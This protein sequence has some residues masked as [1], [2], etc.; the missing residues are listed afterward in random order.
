[1]R[2]MLAS[3]CSRLIPNEEVARPVV[4]RPPTGYPACD[5]LTR[6]ACTCGP[7][8]RERDLRCD[9]AN[10]FASEMGALGSET[11]AERESRCRREQDLVRREC[12]APH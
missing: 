12:Q 4:A 3:S 7:P 6:F 2:D 9:R 5:A 10:A 11:S 1:M 8:G